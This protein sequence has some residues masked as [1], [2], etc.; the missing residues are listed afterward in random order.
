MAATIMT[1]VGRRG[2]EW[3]LPA[4]LEGKA[5]GIPAIAAQGAEGPRDELHAG[6][7]YVPEVDVLVGDL[8]LA[9]AIHIQVGAGQQEDVEAIWMGVD[10]WAWSFVGGLGGVSLSPPPCASARPHLSARTALLGPGGP[11]LPD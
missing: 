11:A 6:V 3:V 10:K 1:A 7:V 9:L 5:C 2:G 4:S 8:Q